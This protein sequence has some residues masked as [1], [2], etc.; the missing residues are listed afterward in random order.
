MHHHALVPL[1]KPLRAPLVLQALAKDPRPKEKGVFIQVGDLC[2]SLL[3]N[4]GL[5]P[6]DRSRFLD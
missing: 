5:Q 3:G 1:L 2:L 6:K 4:T